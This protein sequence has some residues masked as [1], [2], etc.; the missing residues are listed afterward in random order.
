MTGGTIQ[1]KIN[2]SNDINA[3]YYGAVLQNFAE[4]VS[5]QKIKEM[6]E[7]LQKKPGAFQ[8]LSQK[9]STLKS[10]L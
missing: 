3:Q 9:L 10:F 5:E 7:L 1:I 4:N 8:K 6:Y 2:V